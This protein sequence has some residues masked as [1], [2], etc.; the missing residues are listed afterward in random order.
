MPDSFVYS[1]PP[2][3]GMHSGLSLFGA[4]EIL[5]DFQRGYHEEVFTPTSA[6]GPVLEFDFQGAETDIGGTVIDLVNLFVKLDVK[7][8]YF[9]KEKAEGVADL[10]PTFVNN[11]MHNLF[12]NVEISLNGT[13]ISSANNLYPFKALVEAELSHNASCKKGWLRCQGY[14]F[15]TDPGDIAD[16]KAFTNRQKMGNNLTKKFSYYGRLADSFLADNH[17]FLL[18]GVQV[19]VRLYRSPDEIVL[20][21]PNS[22]KETQGDFSLQILNASLLVHKIQLKNKTYLTIERMLSKKAAHYDFREIV[23]KS[24]LISSGV[25][26]YYRDDIFNR[27]PIS[28]L[29]MFMV[30]ETSFSGNFETNPFHFRLMDLETVRLNREGSLVGATPPHL[31]DNLVRFFH[32]SLKALGFE[33]GGNGITLGIF[34]NHFCLLFKLTA[35]Y[36][37]ED[38]AIRPELT[39]A[40]LGLELKFSKT[41]TDPVR[42]IL[43][44]ERRSVVLI[45]RNREVIKHSSIYNG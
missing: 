25:T 44:G 13:P 38:N 32:Q 17:K 27:A 45:D 35:D 12:Q 22:A 31:N 19:R 34:E 37:I 26:M 9:G 1:E 5:V 40:R 20:I 14:E 43:L 2:V 21:H 41:T 18:P 42:L 15:E 8:K 6:D 23:P 30:P 36:H 24:F 28:R 4:S 39:G 3:P 16:G 29:V 10:K 7:L 11:L 33:H